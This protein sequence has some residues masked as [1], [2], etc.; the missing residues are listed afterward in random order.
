MATLTKLF[1]IFKWNT[2]INGHVQCCLI[3]TINNI[4]VCTHF[5]KQPDSTLMSYIMNL[6]LLISNILLQNQGPIENIKNLL[7]E[8]AAT[9]SGANLFLFTLAPFSMS[10]LTIVSSPTGEKMYYSF[11]SWTFQI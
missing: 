1:Y 10:I 11:L 8:R 6:I 7:P 2:V 3:I 5:K 4:Y 9:M